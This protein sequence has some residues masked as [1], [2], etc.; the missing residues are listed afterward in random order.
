MKSTAD[1]PLLTA[2]IINVIY[3]VSFFGVYIYLH[4]VLDLG[5]SS[6]LWTILTF[7]TVN[8]VLDK[9]FVRL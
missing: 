1:L 9:W 7:L 5:I 3:V 2:M 6:I 8:C 4:E